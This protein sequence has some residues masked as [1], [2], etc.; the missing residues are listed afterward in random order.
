VLWNDFTVV[1]GR[2]WKLIGERKT[3]RDRLFDLEADPAEPTG[4]AA[5]EPRI[6]AELQAERRRWLLSLADTIET[7]ARQ[8]REQV[9]H[10]RSL[11][12]L[13]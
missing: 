11:G 1:R 8:S 13:N 2:R 5:R 4:L 7:R 9:E 10:L 6:L 3:G 12:Y